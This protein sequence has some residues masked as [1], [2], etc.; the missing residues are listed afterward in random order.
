MRTGT[1]QTLKLRKDSGPDKLTADLDG[2]TPGA[3]K[4]RWQVLSVDGHISRGDV[5]FTVKER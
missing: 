5:P 2:V 1:S 3:Y 4:L